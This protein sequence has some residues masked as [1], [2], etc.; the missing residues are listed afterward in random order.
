MNTIQTYDL[1]VPSTLEL[2]LMY[3]EL[4]ELGLQYGTHSYI[5]HEWD[6]KFQALRSL[7]VYEHE[8]RNATENKRLIRS[9]Q[10]EC[11]IK[12]TL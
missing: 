7:Y 4:Q 12:P 1:V 2:K 5:Y 8:S 6:R 10:Y 9:L 11:F 3:I